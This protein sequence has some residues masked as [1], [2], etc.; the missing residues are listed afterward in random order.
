MLTAGCMGCWADGKAFF[1]RG[2]MRLRYHNDFLTELFVE[3]TE[4]SVYK[5]NELNVS[6]CNRPWYSS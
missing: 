2:N 4:H 5:I 6:W 3:G 1:G